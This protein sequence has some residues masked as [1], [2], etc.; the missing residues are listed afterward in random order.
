MGRPPLPFNQDIADEICERLAMA[1]SARAIFLDGNIGISMSTMFKWLNLYPDFAEQYAR[2]HETQ[3][4][5]LF[6]QIIDIADTPQI[7]VEVKINSDGKETKHSDMI[8]HRRLQIEARKWVI[9]K[10]RPKKYGDVKTPESDDGTV[11][12]EGGLPE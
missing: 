3:A 7:G 2:A 8:Q 6:A 5:V 1:E 4:D 10:Q 12:I 11:K 9:G